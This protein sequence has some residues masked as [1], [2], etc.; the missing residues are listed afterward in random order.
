MKDLSS[1]CRLRVPDSQLNLRMRLGDQIFSFFFITLSLQQ[2]SS[3]D[4]VFMF[5]VLQSCYIQGPL[6]VASVNKF[7]LPLDEKSLHSILI[8]EAN[9]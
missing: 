1:K 3:K 4:V 7:S 9:R 6:D 2:T 5:Y 8:A